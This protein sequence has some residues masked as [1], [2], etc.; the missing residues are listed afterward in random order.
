MRKLIAAFK[1]ARTRPRAIAWTGT[2]LVAVLFVYGLSM[3]VTSTAWFCNSV[4]HNV[5]AD[6][7]KQW[8]AGTHSEISCM[9]CH[10]PPGLDPARMALDRVD[11]L[12][13]IY[14]AV[15]NTFEMPL[16]A[17]SRI[18]LEMPSDQCTQCHSS[19]REPTAARG[20]LV[21]HEAHE[22]KEI[23]CT[24]CHNRMAH[25]EV[26]ELTL[27]G[28]EKHE[29]F[30]EMRACFRC[31]S[32]GSE[33]RNGFTAAG[34][35]ATCHKPGFNLRPASHFFTATPW[36]GAD[37][38]AGAISG[39]TAAALED[40]ASVALARN[41]WEPIAAEFV[42]EEPGFI[43]RLIDVDTEQPLDLPPVATVEECGMCHAKSFCDDCHA[44][45]QL[46]GY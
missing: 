46:D 30:M 21:G 28:N 38:Y 14:P 19:N 11:K 36:V 3:G 40:S 35:C 12:L 16:N 32:L 17:H 37:G 31:H 24:I 18:A 29:D 39:H 13:D 33:A 23:N 26:F 2:A 41:Q 9:A 15:T 6:N 34:T 5:H 27:P 42:D 43:A 10:Y 20:M 25:P 44:K 8:A 7:A 45:R 4:C 22:A 1:D